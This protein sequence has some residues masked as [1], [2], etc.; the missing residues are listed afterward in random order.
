MDDFWGLH[1]NMNCTFPLRLVRNLVPRNLVLEKLPRNLVLGTFGEL[2]SV[3]NKGKS[4]IP[5][6]FSGPEVLSSASDK[7][8]LF[9]KNVS[10][11]SNLDNLGISLPV[12]TSRTNLKLHNISITP[13]MFKK[14]IMNLD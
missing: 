11:N 12:F 5:P 13:K 4:A 14:V 10:K 2:L 6:L 1:K 9:G 7:A 3:L 8:K